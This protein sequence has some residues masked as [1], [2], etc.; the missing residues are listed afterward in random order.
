[1]EHSAKRLLVT[2]AQ[3]L[4]LKAEKGKMLSVIRYW[5][6]VLS[7]GCRAYKLEAEGSKVKGRSGYQLLIIGDGIDV[8]VVTGVIIQ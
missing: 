6:M 4:K 7:S 8:A 5:L 2:K 3:R 1:M